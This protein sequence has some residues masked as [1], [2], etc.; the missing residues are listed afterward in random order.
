[1]ALGEH[2]SIIQIV[3]YQN[4]GKTT[5]VE[6]L[7]V[8]AKQNGLRVATIKH[9]GHGGVPDDI[10]S[11]KSKDNIRHYKAGA[12]VSSVE[13]DGVLQLSAK[14]DSWSLEKSIK[15]HKF[16]SPHVLFVEGYKQEHYPKVVL[17]RNQNDLSLLHSLTNIMCVISHNMLDKEELK[18][19]R[20]FQLYEDKLYIDFLIKEVVKKSGTKL[21]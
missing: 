12:I 6:K 14:V 7:I 3:G 20:V 1:M 4:S 21:V 17:V 9:H 18:K 8:K 5:L 13:G 2:C 19:H 10:G 16:F 11:A 15:F